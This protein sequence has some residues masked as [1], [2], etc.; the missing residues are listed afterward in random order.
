MLTYFSLSILETQGV[1]T[2][3]KRRARLVLG[4]DENDNPFTTRSRT[5]KKRSHN[6][7]DIDEPTNVTSRSKQSAGSKSVPAKHTVLEDI[8]E[9]SPSRSATRRKSKAQL[10]DIFNDTDVR[11]PPTPQTP[12]HRDALPKKVFVTPKHRISSAAKPLTPR[13][14]RTPST[15]SASAHTAVYNN[16]RQLFTRSRHPGAL[17]CRER[18]EEEL[19]AFLDECV[20]DE[21]SGCIYISGPPGTGKSALVREACNR[22][23]CQSNLRM[24]DVNCVS[25][26]TAKELCIN[27]LSDLAVARELREGEEAGALKELFFE[28]NGIFLVV[29][30]EIDH[31]L[32]I[33]L[34]MLYTLFEFSL[35]PKSNLILVGIANALDFTDRFLPRLKAKGLKPDLL[36]I[37]SYTSEQIAKVITAKLLTLM[38]VG[39]TDFVPFIHPT[40]V[41]FLA[42][43]I[44]AQSGDLRKAFDICRSAIDLIEA[45]TRIKQSSAA[46][47]PDCS[48][49][50]TPLMENINLSSPPASRSSPKKSIR[51]YGEANSKA[52]PNIA[53]LTVENAP[54]ATI[55]HMARVTAK[56]FGNGSSQRLAVLNLQQKAALCALTALVKKNRMATDPFDS[57]PSS[58]STYN[59]TNPST[60]T[61][62]PYD[63]HAPTMRSLY[64]AYSSLCTHD[65]LLH[66]LTNTEF[67]DVVESLE[68]L[69]LVMYVDRAGK[70]NSVLFGAESNS[71]GG[72]ITPSKSASGKGRGRKPAFGFAVAVAEDRKVATVVSEGELNASLVGSG[73]E[74]LRA[75]LTGRALDY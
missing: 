62:K 60:P 12:R 68:N 38:P 26:Q 2:R 41:H 50:K 43:K 30:D 31:F 40:A 75:L 24:T 64:A 20:S 3:A 61:K 37:M 58:M 70:G 69:G 21:T 25:V 1:L 32:D 44:S 6:V 54:R 39:R 11:T 9:I 45:E 36:P 28:G 29:L 65:N 67:R 73:S 17:I 4:N 72:K 23:S 8:T 16:A 59:T 51:S 56:A 27:L 66:P 57:S 14:P 71:N 52:K 55:S 15:P 13:T 19:D 22:L 46:A 5:T 7:F 18:E 48:P 42:K 49:S 47:T 33:D 35:N 74:I 10:V 53:S 63:I 34:D